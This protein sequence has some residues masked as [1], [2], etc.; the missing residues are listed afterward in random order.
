MTEIVAILAI[1][2]TPAA[3]VVLIVWLVNRTLQNEANRKAEIA[4]KAIESGA[5][6]DANIFKENRTIKERLLK[7]LTSGCIWSTLGIVLII[8]GLINKTE[9]VVTGAFILGGLFLS[10][11]ISLILMFFVSKNMLAKEIEAEEKAFEQ[12]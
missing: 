8:I 4:L 10:I 2:V 1:F 7:R 11:G 5:P 6:I 9:G 3:L 12:K